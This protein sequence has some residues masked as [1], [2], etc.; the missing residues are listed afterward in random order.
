[1]VFNT[2]YKKISRVQKGSITWIPAYSK[3]KYFALQDDFSGLVSPKMFQEFFLEQQVRIS[4]QLD[5]SIFHLD[6]PV[7]LGNLSSSRNRFSRWNSVGPRG[8]IETHV[9]VD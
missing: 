7:A 6:G 2:Y 8:S 9:R 4:K 1:M 5:N 3:G